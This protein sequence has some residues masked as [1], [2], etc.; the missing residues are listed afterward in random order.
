MKTLLP[1]PITGRLE[2]SS[3]QNAGATAGWRLSKAALSQ[4]AAILRQ[5]RQRS[6]ERAQ[7]A[8]LDE[9]M[10]RDIGISRGDVLR[11]INKPFWRR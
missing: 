1:L 5:W 8:L 7:L 2:A 4:V 3:R 9:R 11:E 10:L 6:R